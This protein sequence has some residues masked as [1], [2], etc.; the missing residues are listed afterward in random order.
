VT[1]LSVVLIVLCLQACARAQ[2]T[3]NDF[4]RGAEIR[5]GGGTIFRLA[6]PDDV[7]Q[8]VTRPD[9]G[10]LRVLNA[11]GMAVPHTLREAPVPAS[12][13]A[14]WRT[15]PSFPM[16]YV[17]SASGARTQVRVDAKGAVLEVTNGADRRLTTAY[18]VDASG[19]E[20]PATRIALTWQA[21]PEV[22]F[23]AHVSVQGSD[24]L[25]RWRTLVPSA[26]IAQLKRESYTLNQSEIELPATGRVKYLRIS[27]PRE[28]AAVTL[29]GVRVLPRANDRQ[30][31]THWKTFGAEHVDSAG[32][33]LYDTRGVFPVQYVDVE[34]VDAA[35]VAR[36]NV[37]SRPAAESDWMLRHT[38]LFYAL[39]ESNDALR[40]RPARILRIA[41]RY[42]RLDAGREGNWTHDT[43][44]RLKLGWH[45]HE[46]VFVAR[47]PAPYM[48]VYGS[49]RVSA[50]DAP[51]DALLASLGESDLASRVGQATLG[52]AH[53]LGGASALSV[54]PPYRRLAL[55][56]ILVVAVVALGFVALR[57]FRETNTAS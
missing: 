1:R 43:A 44:P 37:R 34:F 3:T 19:L 52:D 27:W 6:L 57:T 56:G 20:Q 24:D 49:G 9:L 25:D 15:V 4:A 12:E 38:G 17:Q 28:L 29:T 32:A 35:D 36:I 48:L 51:V 46:I 14:E 47:G 30:P 16:T 41:D 21:A 42:W 23:L 39:R 54:A 10:D 22:T 31:E 26:A 18:L 13:D 45:P 7:Y 40:S 33:A 5:E 8:T 2:V 53:D 50:T 11:S 55:W